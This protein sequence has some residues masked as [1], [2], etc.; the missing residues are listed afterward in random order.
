MIKQ[1]SS[2]DIP[3]LRQTAFNSSS[4]R[5]ATLALVQTILIAGAARAQ[6]GP[7]TNTTERLPDVVV[8]G[9][10]I[11]GSPEGVREIP[12][13]AAYVGAEDIRDFQQTDV[14][15]V[16]RQVPG[17]YVREEDGYGNFPNV[18]IRGVTTVRNS[19]ITMMED[20]ILT[21]PAPYSDPAAYY[22]PA[23]GRMSGLEIIKGSSQVKYGP[24]ITGGVLNYLSTPIPAASAG[25]FKGYYG[26]D[27]EI[28]G[29]LNYGNTV[30]LGGGRFGYLVEGFYHTSDGF[31]KIDA[32]PGV[33]RDK[34]GFERIEPMIKLAYEPDT[35]AYQRFEVKYGYT[36]FDA[37]ET[38]LGLTE[39][40][41]NSGPQRRYAA[42][43]F[44][45]IAT[46]QHRTYLRHIIEPN[47]NYRITTTAYYN[48]FDRAW[49]KLNN[50]RIAGDT[51]WRD[52]SETLAGADGANNALEV[53]RGNQ[54][55][56]LRVRN[57]NRSY[58]GYGVEHGHQYEFESGRVGHTVEGGV[59]YHFDE[60]S[61][62]QN[63][64]VY[65]QDGTGAIT[66]TNVGAPGSQANREA[67][68]TAWAFYLRDK[69][70]VE[71]WTVTPGVRFET[72]DYSQIN[73]NAAT[74]ARQSGDLNVLGGGVGVDYDWS[75][76]VAFFGGVHHGFAVPGPGGAI[77]NGLDE[78]T[79]ISTEAGVRYRNEQGVAFEGVYFFTAF[80]D[81]I[82]DSNSGGGG[83][84]I[85]ENAGDVNVH[86]VELSASYDPGAANDWVIHTPMAIAFTYTDARF[87]GDASSPDVESIFSGAE[88]G[89]RVP[90]I[91]EYQINARLGAEYERYGLFL[92]ATYVPETFATG[93]NTSQQ[94]RP[95][96]TPDARYG[97][98]DSY[99]VF[100]LMAQARLNDQ[101]RLFAGIRNLT[102]K[103]YIVSRI[104]HGP[105]TGMPR[106]FYGGVEFNF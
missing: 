7:A 25:L 89:N 21:A 96:G 3:S 6:D 50:A 100:D 97:K 9:G 42:T 71:R 22:S 14:N 95:D 28:F 70:E 81:L 69:M 41:V 82:V 2:K 60:T 43:R 38:Y 73:F 65:T 26:S 18:S 87:N 86:G 91:P 99:L 77:G 63:D 66:G 67:D 49:Y 35:A 78:E 53:L 57:N 32:A 54:A 68:S 92:N 11:I 8:S 72:I 76:Q 37:D 88:D 47:D 52:L 48:K 44:D 10:A 64:T 12:G 103:D 83:G 104:P 101:A 40:D 5:L 1:H 13:S 94:V 55:G 74:P 30:D 75:E 33:D 105:R 46:E 93:S 51:T 31:R 15:R 34:T 29:L 20:G 98:T 90:Y 59:R 16:L 85:T 61:R 58:Y 45:N 62:F 79:S 27:N 84:G 23:M 39:A 56:E 80:S 17:V 106:T 4:A 24:H 19:K 102:D 36:D